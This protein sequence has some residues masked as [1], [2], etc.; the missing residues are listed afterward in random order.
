MYSNLIPVTSLFNAEQHGGLEN[1]RSDSF[2]RSLF[3]ASNTCEML[4]EDESR[5]FCQL[6]GSNSVEM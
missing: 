2:L 5:D 1:N 6:R 3:T 4:Q